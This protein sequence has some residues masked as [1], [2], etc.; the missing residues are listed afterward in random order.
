MKNFRK[1]LALVLVVAT[2]FSFAAMA[3]AAGYKDADKVS[4][5]EAVDVLSALKIL[6]GYPEDGTFRPTNSITREE[7]AKMIATLANAG[8][9]VSKLYANTCDFADVAKDRWSASYVAYCNK[10]GIVAG[11]SAT[12]FDPLGKVT[13]LET[14]KMLLVTL[15]FDAKVQGYIGADWKINVLR[16][17]KNFGLLDNFAANYNP[18]AAITREEAANMMLNTLK[19]NVVVGV[20]S[21]NIVKVTNALYHDYTTVTLPDAQKYGWTVM[22]K[23]VIVANHSLF[24]G[25]YGGK[26]TQTG[27]DSFDCQ[28]RP[29]SQWT[30]TD[31]KGHTTTLSSYAMAPVF[32]SHDTNAKEVEKKIAAYEGTQTVKVTEYVIDGKIVSKSEADAAY[33]KGVKV[34]IYLQP[35]YNKDGKFVE[36]HA[37]VVIVNTYLGTVKNVDTNKDRVEIALPDGKTFVGANLYGFKHADEGTK[38]MFE[39]CNSHKAFKNWA[40][41]KSYNAAMHVLKVAKPVEIKL[42]GF[43]NDKNGALNNFC[44]GNKNYYEPA[45]NAKLTLKDEMLGKNYNLYLDEFGYALALEEITENAKVTVIVDGSGRQFNEVVDSNN[46]HHFDYTGRF[47]EFET[48]PTE[49]KDVNID[50]DMFEAEDQN[51]VDRL[52]KYTVDANGARVLAGEAPT[53]LKGSYELNK[54]SGMITGLNGVY[55]NNNTKYLLRVFNTTTGKYEYKFFDG[56]DAIDNNYVLTNLQYF[57]ESSNTHNGSA[58]L[59]YVYAHATY[60][61]ASQ[62]AFITEF[63]SHESYLTE[64]NVNVKCDLY[65]GF[66]DGKEALIAFEQGTFKTIDAPVGKVWEASY[67]LISSESHDKLPIYMARMNDV[68]ES[69]GKDFVANNGVLEFNNGSRIEYKDLANDAKI[70][71]LV[72]K[73]GKI[74]VAANTADELINYVSAHNHDQMYGWYKTENG[75]VSVLYVYVSDDINE[76]TNIGGWIN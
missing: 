59:T 14:A 10:T 20:L 55:G 16:D 74:T 70:T 34:E 39:I 65:H 33:G 41:F 53:I 28:G 37:I 22:Y 35:T 36:N 51:D 62:M 48:N 44:D 66:V 32:T 54:E 63:K 3:S 31:D 52:V 60:A 42:H 43:W 11:R 50:M 19:A 49:S 18:D 57:T 72:K 69:V 56:K 45:H 47:V 8:D 71:V 64:G 75:K 58:Y 9:D 23:N 15:G 5:K 26:L 24:E 68:H 46:V 6:E 21:E 2:L 1:V 73:D 17:A 12:T 4:Y 76:G 25:L 61:K 38:V 29:G 40:E 30:W 13:G 7:M 27:A 67:Q